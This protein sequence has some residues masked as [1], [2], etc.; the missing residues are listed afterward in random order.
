VKFVKTKI[1]FSLFLLFVLCIS[2]IRAQQ[3]LTVRADSTNIVS[4]WCVKIDNPSLNAN[5][6]AI[7]VAEAAADSPNPITVWYR[8]QAWH[9]CNANQSSIADRS[10]FQIR[11]WTAPGQNHFAHKVTRENLLSGG[12]ATRIDN[13]VLNNRPDASVQVYQAIS[14]ERNDGLTA[15]VA[16]AEFSQ[17]ESKWIL[18]N[19]DGKPFSIGNSFNIIIS[20][21]GALGGKEQLEKPT[22]ITNQPTIMTSAGGDLSGMYPNPTVIGLQNR[23]LSNQQPKIGDTLVW[24]G[25]QWKPTGK[26][27]NLSTYLVRGSGTYVP[28]TGV[29]QELTQLSQ[30]FT[31]SRKSRLVI[32]MTVSGST[33][34]PDSAK[35]I[36]ILRINDTVENMATG[37]FTI[38]AG[39]MDGS[40]S[41]NGYMVEVTPGTYNVRFNV[42]ATKSTFSLLPQYASIMVIPME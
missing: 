41:I 39:Q 36:L 15:N 11:F 38:G 37:Y 25:T 30:T 16:K 26:E 20:N 4:R 1:L 9:V 31:V 3:S 5:P 12:L 8:Q 6:N 18:V 29:Q 28:V 10:Q 35:G 21:S 24:D 7:V 40:G 17:A 14:N 22:G 34:S 2:N 23:P 13:S 33:T 27:A 32:N 42:M 19:Q